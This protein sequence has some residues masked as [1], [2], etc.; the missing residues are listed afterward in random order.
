MATIK[1]IQAQKFSLSGSGASIGDTTITLQSFVGIDGTNLVT[2]D[3]GVLAF[4]TLEP[5]NGSQEEAISFTG[6][7]QN[8]NGTATLTGVKS[9]LFKAPYT[10]TTGLTKTHAGASTFILSNDAGFYG[11]ILDYVDTALVSGGVPA[12]TSVNGLVRLSSTSASAST[13]Y[14][15]EN[16]DP[17]MLTVTQAT[18]VAGLATGLSPYSAPIQRTYP[19]ASSGTVWTKPAGLKYLNVELW[20]AGGA[21]GGSTNSNAGAGG[22][23][24]GYSQKRYLTADLASSYIVSIASGGIPVSV[25]T[26]GGTGGNT[27]FGSLLTAYGGGGGA[28]SAG[29]NGGG[30]GGITSAGTTASGTT[31][32]NGGG[33]SGG[34]ATGLTIG[35]VAIYANS[36]FGGGAGTAAGAPSGSSVYGGGGG[37]NAVGGSNNAG[38]SSY[39]GGGGGGGLSSNGGTSTFG[40]AGGNSPSTAGTVPSGGGAGGINSGSSGAGAAG[41]AIITEFYA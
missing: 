2:A 38:G 34:I 15:V 32:G 14:V 13:P 37:G 30:G 40:G 28:S 12:T 25:M 36:N 5:G 27:T 33:L 7:T 41:Q 10:A 39:Y 26:S 16:N 6:V 20:G 21:G 23:G 4:G 8:S 11:A 18:Y 22:G 24:G 29:G 17:R 9:V 1:F 3:L 19:L 31:L 35:G